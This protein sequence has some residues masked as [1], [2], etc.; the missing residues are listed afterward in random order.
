MMDKF[1]EILENIWSYSFV[2]FIVYIAIAF[3][4]A[5]LAK[6]LITK[7][8]KLLKLDEKLQDAI[9]HYYDF[10][11]AYENLLYDCRL[12]DNKVEREVTIASPTNKISQWTYRQ[13]PRPRRINILAREADSGKRVFHLLNFMNVND[14][15]WRDLNGDRPEPPYVDNIELHIDS[16]VRVNRVWAASPDFHGGAPV[17]LQFTQSG[18][19]VTLKVPNLKYW[20][21]VV[22]E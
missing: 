4:V 8:L 17:D 13:G 9:T 19:V 21:M 5:G 6:W 16:D 7:L 18:R 1:K 2:R 12:F 15:S 10:A 22:F 3:A 14:L 11:T 20:T